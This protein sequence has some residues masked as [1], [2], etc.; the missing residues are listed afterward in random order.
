MWGER[1]GIASDPLPAF[2][3]LDFGQ[4]NTDELLAPVPTPQPREDPLVAPEIPGANAPIP[5]SRP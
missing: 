2:N 5:G 1:Y 3:R 4:V